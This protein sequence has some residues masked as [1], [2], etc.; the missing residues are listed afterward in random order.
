MSGG[1][2]RIGKEIALGLARAGS[3]VVVHYGASQNEARD[4]VAEIADLG[5]EALPVQ[6]DLRKPECQIGGLRSGGKNL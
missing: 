4:T 6:A 3:N 1:A 2:R 5:V